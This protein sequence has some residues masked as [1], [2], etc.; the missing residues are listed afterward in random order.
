MNTYYVL[1][2]G[3]NLPSASLA[4]SEGAGK[5]TLD[6]LCYCPFLERGNSKFGP[7]LEVCQRSHGGVMLSRT[8]EQ[9]LARRG[10]SA[11]KGSEA[12]KQSLV[13]LRVFKTGILCLAPAV[14]ELSPSTRLTSNSKICM[15]LPPTCWD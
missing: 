5:Q 3:Q 4:F 8:S 15:P 11:G 10:D 2:C 14:L 1:S 9:Q 7:S 13:F 12:G 6:S